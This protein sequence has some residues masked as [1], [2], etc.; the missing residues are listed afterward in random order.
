M[1]WRA[2]PDP[3]TLLGILQN[4]AAGMTLLH[5]SGLLHG[6]LRVRCLAALFWRRPLL[7]REWRA[8]DLP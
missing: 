2:A 7:L 1:A 5:A 6:D 3:E 4:V 8:K